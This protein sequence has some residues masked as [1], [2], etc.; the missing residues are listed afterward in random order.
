MKQTITAR[1][2][3]YATWRKGVLMLAPLEILLMVVVAGLLVMTF[4]TSLRSP[5]GRQS[6]AALKSYL[7]ALQ[8]RLTAP[9]T[10]DPEAELERMEV[11]F[12]KVKG[13]CE[14]PVISGN[15]EL[16]DL[17]AQTQTR[18]GAIDVKQSHQQGAWI[19]WKGVTHSFYNQY[20]STSVN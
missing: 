18:M 12:N 8:A 1:I 6:L 10:L 2:A 3:A 19:Q 17:L 14:Q 13:S 4:F 11:L 16:Q 9:A 20:F 5:L 7:Q 15:K